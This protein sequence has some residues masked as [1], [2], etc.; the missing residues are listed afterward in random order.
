MAGYELTTVRDWVVRA[1][2][3]PWVDVESALVLISLE[4]VSVATD[5]NVAVELAVQGGKSWKNNSGDP[6]LKVLSY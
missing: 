1:R 4:F 3:R 5:E 2:D 6:L